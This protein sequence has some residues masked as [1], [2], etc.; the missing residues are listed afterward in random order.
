[1]NRQGLIIATG[2]L[3]KVEEFN[4]LLSGSI[5]EVLSAQTCGGM[6]AVDETG[7]TFAANA[8]LKAGALRA[9]APADAWVLAD[10][11]GLEVD[12]LDGAPGVYSARYAGPAA[13]DRDNMEKLLDALQTVPK[14]ARC[15]R[16]RCALCVI[17]P[18]GD[19]RHYDGCCEGR[20]D[21]EPHGRQGFGYDPIFIPNG[22]SQ[23]FAQ[24]G[25]AIKR[26]LSHR[27][28]AVEHMRRSLSQ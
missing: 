10:D 12:A 25:D 26:Q 1:M 11:S 24:L 22:Y 2:N 18:T 20:I 9:H 7:S 3:H 19:I 15:A 6:P 23:S 4:G 17:A 8:Q 14:T 21:M 16:F 28:K 5:F 27:A 13:S